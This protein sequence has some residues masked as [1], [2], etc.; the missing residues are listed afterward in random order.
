MNSECKKDIGVIF[1][2]FLI[3]LISPI[4][5]VVIYMLNIWRNVH[6][7]KCQYY[8]LFTFLALWLAGMNAT[9]IPASDQIAY[10]TM[11]NNVPNF[12]FFEA[13]TKLQVNMSSTTAET[14]LEPVYKAFCY[15]GYY[16][17]FGN[18]YWYFALIT[19]IIYM[20]TFY[21]IHKVLSYAG[22]DGKTII[23]GIIICAFFFQFFNETAHAIRQ[24]LSGCFVL[25]AILK[26]N[27]SGKNQWWLY[28]LA[29]LT[30]KST[31][32]FVLFCLIPI[33]FIEKKKYLLLI[34]VAVA[35][36]TYFMSQL[37]T[38]LMLL[39]FGDSYVL[40]RAANE[41]KEFSEMNKLILYGVSVP[42]IF[43]CLRALLTER[44]E[45][46]KIKFFLFICLLLSVFVVF[47]G[48][49]TLFQARY[50]FYLYSIVPFVIPLLFKQNSELGKV[51]Q[52][53]LCLFMPIYF[54]TSFKTCIW[55]YADT[56]EL[57]LFPFPLL[58]NYF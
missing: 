18:S 21:C 42:L 13:L 8:G 52:F 53:V 14:Y 11:Y 12:T 38:T 5:S 48:K 56:I 6:P 54:F 33:K 57:L 24:F 19:F 34:V 25:L 55:Q 50:F 22:H 44:E 49:N 45:N 40:E 43:I 9:K 10:E 4:F 30:H 16:L 51:Y 28:A 15:I 2:Y 41:S 23:T 47:C 3:F 58:L 39:G 29:L 17:T 46:N 26:K 27:E 7:S 1:P 20:S 32:L 35:V 36:G 31:L 37:S